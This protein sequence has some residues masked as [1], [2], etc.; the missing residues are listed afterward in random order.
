MKALQ[1]QAEQY[2]S[3]GGIHSAAIGDA[4]GLLLYAEDIGRHNTFDRLAGEALFKKIELKDKM[5][6]T[7]G[8]VSSE[9]VAKAARLAIG[10][11][12]SRTS[13]TDKAIELCEQAGISLVGYLRGNSMEIYSH[14]QQID[15]TICD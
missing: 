10:L 12:A 15:S 14:P 9:M 8:R 7:S 1:S 6:V 2:R 13:P 11:I 5:L 3:H 4:D